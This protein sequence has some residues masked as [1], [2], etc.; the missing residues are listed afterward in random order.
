MTVTAWLGPGGPSTAYEWTRKNPK[1]FPEVPQA[2]SPDR[3]SISGAVDE[4]VTWTLEKTGALD[5]LDQVTGAPAELSAAARTWRQQAEAMRQVA[6]GLRRGAEPLAEA[7][8]GSASDGFGSHMGDV[9]AA[10][11]D[12]A[13]DMAQTAYI[14]GQA[15][16]ECALAE[17]TIIELISDLITMLLAEL[18]TS[19]VLDL[20][21]AGLA[22]VVDAL[23]SEAE[24]AAGIARIERISQKLATALRELEQVVK[25]M[26]TAQREGKAVGEIAK[27]ALKVR[28]AASGVRK[29]AKGLG[30]KL[31]KDEGLTYL[32][33]KKFA[34]PFKQINKHVNEGL[35]IEKAAKP[36]E[37]YAEDADARRSLLQDGSEAPPA[38]RVDK[39]SLD[40]S[41]VQATFG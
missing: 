19:F 11:D 35:G 8:T 34:Q 20:F 4:A 7:W 38:Y 25:E 5:L 36:L 33:R 40:P 2:E 31:G 22:T 24:I 3:G 18:A 13:Y 12:T 23:A 32:Q 15:A 29:T 30:G 1:E 21:T 39:E 10:V 14:L 27:K 41:G 37:R 6:T 26:R 17:E 9:V 16:K 28:R